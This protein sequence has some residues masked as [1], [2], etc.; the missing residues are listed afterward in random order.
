MSRHHPSILN[1]RRRDGLQVL[2]VL[3]GLAGVQLLDVSRDPPVRLK[4]D[5][6]I[7]S[8]RGKPRTGYPLATGVSYLL[9][10]GVTQD[11]LVLSRGGAFG[12]GT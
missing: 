5:G 4:K 3:L 1:H 8:T 11:L 7:E 6:S 2:E 10:P 12:Q 9:A